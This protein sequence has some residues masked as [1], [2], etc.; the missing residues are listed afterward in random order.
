M[1][2]QS[3]SLIIILIVIA[4]YSFGCS[5]DSRGDNL[6]NSTINVEV[7]QV[8]TVNEKQVI[9]YSG[10][11]EESESIPLSFSGIGTVVKVLVSEGDFVKKGQLLAIL[12]DETYKNAYEVSLALLKQA[13]DAYR[14]LLPM[15]KN[16]NLPDIKLVEV[17]TG[18]QQAKS[19]SSIA[20]K[21]LDD[22]KLY[23]TVD[24]IVG[25]RSIEPG[26]SAM[27]NLASITIVKI[28]K[29]FAKVPISENE[30]SLL[31]KGDKAKIKIGALNNNEFIGTVEEIGVL[32][33]PIAHTYKIK[34][35]IN[36]N[37]RQ[38]KPGM[39]CNVTIDKLNK[40][41]G[42]FVSSRAVLVDEQGKSFVFAINQNKSIKK[43]VK[44]GKL[45]KNGVEIIEGLEA[46]EK[47]VVTGQ[48]KLVDNSLINI[49]NQ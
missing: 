9:A 13:E 36:N 8:K 42:L 28:E 3:I 18:L 4:L 33:D 26:M 46:G 35:G 16:G 5:N 10:T 30:I 12:N 17:E 31:K 2:M 41:E 40:N 21:S 11:I 49:V 27:P 7:E 1:K 32:A 48:Q 22:C 23:S 39:I 29:V 44:T 43:Y 37:A 38:I 6:Q 25:K 45:L 15:S 19:S 14:R 20:K 34:I 24:G 47:V